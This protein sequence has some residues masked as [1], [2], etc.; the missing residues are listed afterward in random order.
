MRRKRRE[1][2]NDGPN[3][4]V[5]GQQ[6]DSPIMPTPS[7]TIFIWIFP[8]PMWLQPPLSFDVPDSQANGLLNMS[9]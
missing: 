9:S 7:D 1:E 4:L 8:K 2:I 3:N 5:E 6:R